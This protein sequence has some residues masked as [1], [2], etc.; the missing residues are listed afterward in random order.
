MAVPDRFT[1]FTL[2]VMPFRELSVI[3]AWL[4]SRSGWSFNRLRLDQMNDSHVIED[5]MSF[6]GTVRG[7]KYSHMVSLSSEF[8]SI[9]EFVCKLNEL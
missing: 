5:G 6:K 7:L 4:R 1:D 8:G 9:M 3:L 2:E